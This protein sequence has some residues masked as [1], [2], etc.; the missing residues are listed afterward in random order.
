LNWKLAHQLLLPWGTSHQFAM[1]FRVWSPY[2]TEDR[3]RQTDR[4]TGK[5]H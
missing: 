4:Q 5:T 3:D 2:G 1:P